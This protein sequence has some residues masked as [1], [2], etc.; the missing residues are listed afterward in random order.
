MAA[1]AEYRLIIARADVPLVTSS[2]LF[3][4]NFH[5]TFAI[6]SRPPSAITSIVAATLTTRAGYTITTQLS[7]IIQKQHHSADVKSRALKPNSPDR[8]RPT[9]FMHAMPGYQNS[10][11]RH[12]P[13]VIGLDS[14]SCRFQKHTTIGIYITT[15]EALYQELHPIQTKKT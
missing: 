8:P 2:S 13:F 3:V 14:G 5:L 15:T 12:R 1:H 11:C 10:P 9:S 6:T 7:Q 4:F